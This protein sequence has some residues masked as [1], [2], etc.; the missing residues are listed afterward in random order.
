MKITKMFGHEDHEGHE[1][2]L[3]SHEDPSAAKPQPN[4]AV[5]AILYLSS[6]TNAPGDFVKKATS[7]ALVSRRCLVTKIAKAT[8]GR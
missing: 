2:T 1:G 7:G 5:I 4:R 3:T 6:D 8:K